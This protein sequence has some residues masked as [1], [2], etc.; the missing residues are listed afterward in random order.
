MSAIFSLR[1]CTITY[2]FDMCIAEKLL[3][4]CRNV[5]SSDELF[6]NIG[7][8]SQGY[9]KDGVITISDK[10][11]YT[12]NFRYS[13]SLLEDD[14]LKPSSKTEY[15]TSDLRRIELKNVEAGMTELI[16]GDIYSRIISSN[17][18]SSM[19]SV[20]L[21][22]TYVDEEEGITETINKT[23]DITVDWYG[24]ATSTISSDESQYDFNSI[25][26]SEDIIV[27]YNASVKTQGLLAKEVVLKSEIPSLY[28]Y[29]PEVVGADEG[30]YDEE[31]H[32]LTRTY[33]NAGSTVYFI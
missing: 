20:T 28:G 15:V 31:T 30:E 10:E 14:V 25:S 4:T 1:K 17:S 23:I 6:I 3:G 18:Y 29:Y 27:S 19:G 16:T 26:S 11:G 7:V 33:Q 5:N 21:T 2:F 12:K 13:T 32:T 22:G 8:K 9:L 24:E